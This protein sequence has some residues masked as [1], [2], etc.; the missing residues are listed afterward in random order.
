[1]SVRNIVLVNLNKYY[2]IEIDLD[3]TFEELTFQIYS[4]TS[5]PPQNQ[6][7]LGLVKDAPPNKDTILKNLQIKDGQKVIVLGRPESLSG[8]TETNNTEEPNKTTAATP[9]TTSTTNTPK[10]ILTQPTI[11]TRPS[12]Q[13]THTPPQPY[14]SV[15]PSKAAKMQNIIKRHYQS[16]LVYEDEL[17]QAQALSLLP[18]SITTNRK[19]ESIER[20][21]EQMRELL[22]WFKY[23]FFKWVNQPPCSSCNSATVF[24]G[25]GQPTFEDTSFKAS[26]IEM[27]NC[28]VNRNHFTRFPRYDDPGKLLETRSGRC[29]EWAN[30]FALFCRALGYKTR[31]IFDITDHVWTEIYDE[32]SKRWIHCDCCEA[33]YDTPL[34]YETGW[35]KKLSYILAFETEG[36][37]D[38]SQRYTLKMEELLTRRNLVPEDWLKS[39]LINLNQQI[40][41]KLTQTELKQLL[42]RIELEKSEFQTSHLRKP[43]G[44]DMVPRNSGSD[45][46]KAQRGECGGLNTPKLEKSPKPEIPQLLFKFEETSPQDNIKYVGD[47]TKQGKNIV[48]TPP[49]NDKCG[50]FWVKDQV[51]L[52]KDFICRFSFII[53]KNGADG[54]AFV[55][56]NESLNSLGKRGCGLGY[57]GIENSIAVEFDTYRSE[58]TCSDP[59]GNHISVHTNG[60]KKN[61][62]HHRYSLGYAFP[63]DNQPMNDGKEHHCSILYKPGQ[64]LSIWFDNYFLITNLHVDLDKLLDLNDRK[65]WI[66]MTGSTGG[67]SQSH[68]ITSFEFGYI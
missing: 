53:N 21:E 4:L 38:V 23:E 30:A 35:G 15:D 63:F 14:L 28:S 10:P 31:Y 68:T 39:F 32:K 17:L 18:S 1:M 49:A 5:I 44:E 61:S 41:T 29:G 12:A 7:L 6:K 13:P 47:C 16:V 58:D 56:Q 43:K 42:E 9:T 48:L 25:H 59:N 45:E 24:T 46:W 8:E 64:G 3:G 26:R 54:M 2:N 67:I 66:G 37:F 11:N 62:A 20:G 27:Y 55:I 40:Q 34:I 22:H 50:G 51:D 60:Q 33:A 19:G 57:D 65:A 36:V 52:S